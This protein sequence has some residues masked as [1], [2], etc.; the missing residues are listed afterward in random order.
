M[1]M[2]FFTTAARSILALLIAAASTHLDA[3]ASARAA[4]SAGATAPAA[5]ASSTASLNGHAVDPDDAG[6]AGAAVRLTQIDTGRTRET[7]TDRAGRFAFPL[8]APGTYRLEVT[9]E[10]FDAATLEPL[11]LQVNDEL[12]IRVVMRVRGVAE[13]VDV[14]GQ[15]SLVRDTAAVSTSVPHI[16]VDR[17]PLNG[18][19]L[20]SLLLLTPGVNLNPTVTQGASG[21]FSINGQR[22]SGNAF[23]VDGV[24]ANVGVTGS[25]VPGEGGSGSLPALTVQGGTS[26]LVSIEALQEFSVQ[27]S[28][29]SAEFGRTPGGQISVV[30]RAGTN[31]LGGTLFEYFR[32]DSLDA[33]DFFVNRGGLPKPPLRQHQFGGALG[34]PV[35]LGRL[36]DG[37]GRTHFFVSDE[38]L[39]LEQPQAISSTTIS[40]TSRTQ[41]PAAIRPLFDAYPLPTGADLGGGLARFDA[42]YSTPSRARAT[43][44]RLDHAVG[45][46][47]TTFGRYNHAPSSTDERDITTPSVV[48]HEDRDTDTVTIGSTLILASSSLLDLRYNYSTVAAS[49]VRTLDTFGGAIPPPSSALLPEAAGGQGYVNVNLGG[50]A[51]GFAVGTD[52][53]NRQ[54]QHQLV[55]ALTHAFGAHTIKAGADW[56]HFRST[57]GTDRDAQ[58]RPTYNFAGVAGALAGTL[59]S[60]LINVREKARLDFDNLSL[61]VQD[62]WRPTA[63]LTLSY[64]LRYELNPAPHGATDAEHPSA[65]TTIEPLASVGLAPPG[66]R[67]YATSTRTAGP[68]AGAVYRLHDARG[69]TTTI[70]GGYGLYFDLGYGAVANAAGA[71]PLLRTKRLGAGT[72]FPLTAASAAPLAADAGPPYDLIRALDPNLQ[73]P[74][75]HQYS[76]GVD[77]QLGGARTLTASYVGADGRRLLRQESVNAPNP[78]IG[79][80]QLTTNR[81]R[82]EYDALQLQFV[83]RTIANLVLQAGYTLSR[84]TDTSSSAASFLPPTERFDP[85]LDE[86]PSDFDARHALSGAL[87]WSVPAPRGSSWLSTLASGWGLDAIVHARS[88]Q[89]FSVTGNRQTPVGFL[90]LRPDRVADVPLW[91]DD[92]AVPGGR[93]IN[94]LAFAFGPEPRHGSLPRNALR[95]FSFWQMDLAISRRLT[96]GRSWRAELR[97]EAFNVFNH[98]NFHLRAARTSLGL[99]GATGAF[100]APPDFGVSTD[101]LRSA[102]AGLNPL[103][104]VGGPRSVQLSV[105][106]RF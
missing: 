67:L 17:L 95:G 83:D 81:D 96:L 32:D 48:R 99:I 5:Q 39:R 84:S 27:T 10:G 90:A 64:G 76:V 9:R 57:F 20:Q 28:T 98:A 82:S 74:R 16:L 79:I 52:A 71:F 47:V 68:R 37:R 100:T 53:L 63:R 44:L 18:R 29:Y 88:G 101:M 45:S 50:T 14:A 106:V 103:Y 55:A 65:V 38:T 104:R 86:G 56:R 40:T 22:P 62:D 87:S 59:T 34:G 31:V 58:Y 91:I 15:A 75:T 78:A 1:H 3:T 85:A 19:N 33:T 30:T 66:P 73:L 61:Y 41:A 36:Y 94:P 49:T 77:Q 80:L 23:I 11:M 8:L 24:S 2:S 60:G 26:S 13:T 54:R 93:R 42:S 46:R 12:A 97:A 43:S 105:R 6:V 92:G 21:Q 7:A 4:A 102:Y 51:P 89:P 35:W 25:A 70:R 69:W 72:A